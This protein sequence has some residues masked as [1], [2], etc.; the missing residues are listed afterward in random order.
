MTAAPMPGR[1]VLRA[2]LGAQF[3]TSLADNA[4]LIVAIA[5]LAERAAPG[6]MTP[7]LRICLYL[8]YVL[9]APFAGAL[10]DALPKGRVMLLATLARLGAC[11]A[12]AAKCHPVLAFGAAGVLGACY[13]PAKYG[14][15]AELIPDADLVAANAWIEAATVAS[16]LGGVALGSLLLDAPLW[17]ASLHTPALQA[18]VLLA[19]PYA[20]AALCAAAVPRTAIVPATGRGAVAR[21]A[22][23]Q[24]ILWRD[25]QARLSL[26]VTTLFWAMAAVLQFL[27]IAWAQ[28][29][30]KLSLAQAA[31]LQCCLAIGVIAGSLA[32]IRIVPA[33][34][35]AKVLPA[36]VA[37]GLAIV[38]TSGVDH[39]WP[40]CAL[41][42]ACGIAAGIVLV[43]MNAL[44]QRRG[45]A[46]MAPGASIAVQGFS[47][48]LASL[49]FL[50][51]YGALLAL[52]VPLRFL[53]AGFGVLV[54]AAMLLIAQRHRVQGAAAA[55]AI[56]THPQ[57]E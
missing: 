52:D 29:V 24:A 53:V 56:T 11:A 4:L 55:P 8:S 49:A 35:A 5:L 17:A 42:G 10:A 25:P 57:K 43:P 18:S 26:A 37:L 50:A 13:G 22:R 1:A 7:S 6:W 19:V 46:L 2:L 41:L 47:E 40:A 33:D 45:D 36:G 28:D 21:F 15:L 23:Q 16:I 39:L 12:M 34:A 51:A 20:I 32:A 3:F 30:L 54:T 31:L 48:N 14:A 27:V 44:L 38:L 9:L